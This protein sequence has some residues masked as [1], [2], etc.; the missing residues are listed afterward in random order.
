MKTLSF[1]FGPIFLLSTLLVA[2][3]TPP[4][5]IQATYVSDLTY[6]D[7][8]CD[9]I[10]EE[11]VRIQRRVDEL[12][13]SLKKTASD[14]SA[15]MGIGLIFFW[16]TL[17]FLEGGDG[18]QAQEYARLKGE[19]EAVERVSIQRRCSAEQRNRSA[20]TGSKQTTSEAALST[21]AR[22]EA[23]QNSGGAKATFIQS[24]TKSDLQRYLENEQSC[25]VF[26]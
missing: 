8:D 12:H 23:A 17:F 20:S 25:S 15:Q 7:Y 14:D 3:A 10:A 9:Q 2:C 24:L 21:F 1:R 4:D 6:R 26:R 5:K 18:P 19:A 13:A 11:S 16:P 22:C